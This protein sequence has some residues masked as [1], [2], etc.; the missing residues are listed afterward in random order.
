MSKRRIGVYV[1]HCG[2]NISDYVDVD[3]VVDAV[4]GDDDV[5]V[6]KDTMFTCSDA[7]Q[8]VIE[9]DIRSENLDGLVVASCSPKLHTE[10]FREVA[11]RA[12]LNPYEYTQ[13][14]IREQC[15]WTHTD[16]R[17]GAT[18]KAINLVRG[19]IART[20]LTEPLEATTVETTSHALVIG[21]GV[22]GMR[23]AIGLADVGLGVTLV[24]R[25]S[26][27]G[28]HTATLSAL[29]PNERSG[30]VLVS[31]L[32]RE[33]QERNE[34]IVFTNAEVTAKAGTFGNYRVVIRVSDQDESVH[35]K[36]GQI[37]VA[38]GFDNYEPQAGEYGYGMSGVV[39]LPEFRKMLD[40]S[41]PELVYD[42]KPVKTIAYIYCVGS[43][44]EAQPYCS[45]Y[46]CT[47]AVHTSLLADRAT[48]GLRQYHLYRDMRTYGKNELM[49]SE[50]RKHGS[51]Y[52]KFADDDPPEVA[53]VNGHLA[54]TLRDLLS[55]S[56][57]LVV[58]ADLVVLVTGMMPR[59]NEKLIKTLKMPVGR[60]GFF[61]EIH[62]KLRPVET[63]VDGVLI[64]GACQSP[65][66]VS[67]SVTSGL[68]AVAQTA[69]VLKR[70][71]AELDPQ[72]ARVDAIACTGCE[73]CVESCQFAAISMTTV[74][75]R[76]VAVIDAAGCKGC[77]ACAPS[78]P[79]DAIDL[80]GY[81]DAEMRAIID[82]LLVGVAS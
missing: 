47:A 54:V 56:Q 27:L 80:L 9:H 22:A 35:V 33:I 6:V 3:Q 71:V 48:P 51:V 2:G 72:V 70:G 32:K 24:E 25:A 53:Q 30:R 20:R 17:E 39:T 38:T 18:Q 11:R 57:E 37:I 7:T 12:G 23:A 79:E 62:P 49:L 13:V 74:D 50:S 55:D 67:E 29:Y 10:T 66:T 26:E 1:C 4:K 76:A 73:A 8:Q 60:D 14:N 44:C 52:M 46:C 69:A 63:V 21:G 77:G 28:G 45:R 15:S 36:V 40:E 43:R 81:T 16:D 42:G 59:E 75:D 19:G 82:G 5:I 68:A 61:N 64:A 41:G 31:R 58:P 65:K 34:I 78:C